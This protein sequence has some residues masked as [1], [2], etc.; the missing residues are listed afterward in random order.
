MALA[1]FIS[2][3]FSCNNKQPFVPDYEI[4]EGIIIGMEKCKT[5]PSQNA[6]LIHIPGPNPFNKT[7]GDDITFNGTAY[8]NVV[9]TLSLPDSAKVPGKKYSF[10]FY[11]DENSSDAQCNVVNPTVLN[12]AK[13]RIKNL[14]RTS[15]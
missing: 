13:I 8:K 6:W 12:I 14:N 2:I 9:K 11:I 10:E 3:F 4:G 15:N 1:F 5:D 7:Y